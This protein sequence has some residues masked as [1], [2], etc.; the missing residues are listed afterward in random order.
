MANEIIRPT[1]LP[2]RADPVESE[3]VP[4][5]NGSSV[6][7]VTWADG[8]NAAVPPASQPES[9]AGSI[10]TKRMTPLTT[11]QAID[12]QV[13]PKISSAIGALNL[14]SASQAQV[15]DFAT[16]VQGAN[17]DSAVQPSDLAAV[18]T[19]GDY[20][21]LDNKPTARL[22][23]SGGLTS[24]AL[25][26]RSD[27]DYDTEW[28]T[29]AAATAVSYA[30]QIL[31]EP[32][33]SQARTNISAAS[34][35]RAVIGGTANAIALTDAAPIAVGLM[36]RFRATAMNTDTATIAYNGGSP[37]ACR[38]VT[39]AALPAGYIRNDVDTEAI[40]DGTYWVLDRLE[41]RGSN[42]NGD[43]VR[44]A[45]GTQI[46]WGSILITPVPDTPTAG[47]VTFPAEFIAPP[48][49]SAIANSAASTYV[50]TTFASPAATSF[51][52]VAT[53]TN[54][55]ATTHNWQ[56]MGRWK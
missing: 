13:P 1:Q 9:E 31:T 12:A 47:T 27:S 41:E 22:L 20:E 34:P 45:E 48:S 30:P 29:S 37:I 4:S 17:A 56:A 15:E 54:D 26:K 43:Y 52:V 55:V 35:F 38:T 53:R 2:A 19:S 23:P 51:D 49:V 14:G 10:N 25:I 18:A 33:Q 28:V 32:Q 6:A 24:Q 50:R 21:D 8:V 44:F 36:V 16:A 11:K 7:G 5:D 46:C 42:A 40:Y 3:V 39:G